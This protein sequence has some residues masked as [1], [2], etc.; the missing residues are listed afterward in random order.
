MTLSR[1]KKQNRVAAVI[2]SP[3]TVK[4]YSDYEWELLLRQGRASLLLGKLD[5]YLALSEDEIVLPPKVQ[6]HL[7][8]PMIAWTRQKHSVEWELERL[9]GDLQK[10]K[11]PLIVLKGAAYVVSNLDA[12]TGRLF[13]DID[14]L[15]SSKNLE[16]I[17]NVLEWK[18]WYEES[19]D[20]YDRDYYRRWMHEL[21][22]MKNMQTGTVLD[23]HH[24]ILPPTACYQPD[25]EKMLAAVR[26]VKRGIYVLCPEDMVIH[27]ATHLFHEGEFDHGLR[28]L[29]DIDGLLKEFGEKEPDFWKRLVPRA[30]ELGLIRPLYYGLHYGRTILGT[31]VPKIVMREAEQ[32]QPNFLMSRVM[33]FLFLRALAPDHPTCDRP[34]TGLARWLLYV[35]SHYLRMPLYLLVPHLVRKAWK[36]RFE[37]KEAEAALPEKD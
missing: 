3:E 17:Q 18:G 33:D 25:P 19:M 21:P 30:V 27:S 10:A 1:H 16:Q 15:V 9:R 35:R 5:H 6:N 23:I 37:K 12:A 29:V 2:Q 24:T 8:A 14:I 4:G 7:N 31:P 28:D 36:S 22:P 13:N 32:G 34:F 11:I 26:E 20:V